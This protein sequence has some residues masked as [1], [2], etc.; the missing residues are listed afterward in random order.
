M[1]KKNKNI[2]WLK[3]IAK[4]CPKFNHQSKRDIKDIENNRKHKSKG[5]R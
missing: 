2:K 3:V 1:S 4:I 5:Q